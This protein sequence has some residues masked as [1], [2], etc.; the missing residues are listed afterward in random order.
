MALLS[1]ILDTLL[2][3]IGMLN[4]TTWILSFPQ[5]G[6]I[7]WELLNQKSLKSPQDFQ[8]AAGFEILQHLQLGHMAFTM[9][10]A[11]P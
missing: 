11:Y 7:W 9:L 1:A 3:F 4:F 5:K 2:S 10:R 6:S 8:R